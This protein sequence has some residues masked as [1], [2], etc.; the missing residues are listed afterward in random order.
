MQ[1][2][3][4]YT[5]YIKALIYCSLSKGAL[6]NQRITQYTSIMYNT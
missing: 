1:I 6:S 4:C 2:S 3:K 5:C